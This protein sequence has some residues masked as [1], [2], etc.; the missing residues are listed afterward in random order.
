VVQLKKRVPTNWI[1]VASR[2]S[3]PPS[4]SAWMSCR[5]AALVKKSDPT[6]KVTPTA[7]GSARAAT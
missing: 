5:A 4:R 3:H 1:A 7:I 6:K 2:S